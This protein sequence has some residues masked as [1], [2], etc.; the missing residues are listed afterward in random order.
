MYLCSNRKW[1]CDH[2]FEIL[3]KIFTL[4]II[5]AIKSSAYQPKRWSNWI[6]ELSYWY[7]VPINIEHK[8]YHESYVCAPSSFTSC[9][10]MKSYLPPARIDSTGDLEVSKRSILCLSVWISACRKLN[11]FYKAVRRAKR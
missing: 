10:T 7:K 1:V 5:V 8:F 2:K 3:W 9:S 4:T 11:H 6:S